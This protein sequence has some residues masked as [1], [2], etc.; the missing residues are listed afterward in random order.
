MLSQKS[1]RRKASGPEVHAGHYG[2]RHEC[3]EGAGEGG[4]SKMSC[5]AGP[6]VEL[7]WPRIGSQQVKFRAICRI[8]V[9]RRVARLCGRWGAEGVRLP[10]LLSGA[11]VLIGRSDDVWVTARG[12]D[13]MKYSQ[14]DYN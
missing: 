1:A 14:K 6:A 7:R 9:G 10:A 13:S 3:E 4:C 12:M 8:M 11:C 2:R 5:A